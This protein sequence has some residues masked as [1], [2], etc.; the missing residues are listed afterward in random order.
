[1]EQTLHDL[2]FMCSKSK[3]FISIYK[4]IIMKRKKKRNK[5][6]YLCE[7]ILVKKIDDSPDCFGTRYSKTDPADV[8]KNKEMDVLIDSSCRAGA[9]D[10]RF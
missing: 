6:E 3:K 5:Y 1:M 4:I 8:L 9:I 10:V 7:M 2:V